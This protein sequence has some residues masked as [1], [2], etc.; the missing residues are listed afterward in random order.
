LQQGE[1]P[2]LRDVQRMAKISRRV[3]KVLDKNGVLEV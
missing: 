2:T 1:V 3:Y